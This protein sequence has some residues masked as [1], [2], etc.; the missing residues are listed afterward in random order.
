MGEY[1]ATTFGETIA[2]QYD[3]LY[4]HIVNRIIR[5]KGATAEKGDDKDA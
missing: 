5:R 2:D 1:T 4:P 3:A